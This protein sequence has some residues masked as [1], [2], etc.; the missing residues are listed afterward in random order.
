MKD[1]FF[2]PYLSYLR[3]A[4]LLE[5]PLFWSTEDVNQIAGSQLL[6]ERLDATDVLGRTSR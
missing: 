5:S 3:E 1:R 4:T 2:E 6:D